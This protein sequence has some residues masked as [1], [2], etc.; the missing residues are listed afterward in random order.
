MHT[1]K[2]LMFALQAEKHN[3]R[4]PL[5]RVLK[6]KM[7][8]EDLEEVEAEEK[9]KEWPRILRFFGRWQDRQFLGETRHFRIHFYRYSVLYLPP[10]CM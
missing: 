2:S 9:R 8:P 4:R 7:I 10:T 6:T 5:K 3:P 1:F